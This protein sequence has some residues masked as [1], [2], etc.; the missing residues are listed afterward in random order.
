MNV[1]NNKSIKIDQSL[2]PE[3]SEDRGY[4]WWMDVIYDAEAPIEAMDNIVALINEGFI[5][6]RCATPDGEVN[7]MVGVYKK[8]QL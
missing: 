3:S 7:N 6:G 1:Q 2:T 4:V 8:S 5:L